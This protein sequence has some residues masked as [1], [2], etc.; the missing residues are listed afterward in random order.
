[1]SNQRYYTVRIP[2]NGIPGSKVHVQLEDG[3]IFEV[4]VPNE[5]YPGTTITVAVDEDTPCTSVEQRPKEY[6]SGMLLYVIV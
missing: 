6:S 1:M 5:C 4:T 3:R 2:D